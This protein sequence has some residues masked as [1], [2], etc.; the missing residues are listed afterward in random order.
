MVEKSGVSGGGRALVWLFS[1]EKKRKRGSFGGREERRE[2]YRKGSCWFHWH[3]RVEEREKVRG[4]F[5][6]F[7]GVERIFSG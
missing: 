3:Y 2:I 5:I 7:G 1:V 6:S 4:E